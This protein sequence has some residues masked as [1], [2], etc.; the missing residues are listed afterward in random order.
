MYITE[1]IV[2]NNQKVTFRSDGKISIDYDEGDSFE[3][4]VEE[5]EYIVQVFR[6][7]FGNAKNN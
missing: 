1:T 5:L 3:T 4:N 7:R 2:F 6:S